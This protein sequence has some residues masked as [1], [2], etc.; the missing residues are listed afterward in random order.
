MLEVA[1]DDDDDFDVGV[2]ILDGGG[3]DIEVH[4]IP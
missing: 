2:D 4:G 3:G 1:P